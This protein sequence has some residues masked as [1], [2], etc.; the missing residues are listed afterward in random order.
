MKRMFMAAAILLTSVT[1]HAEITARASASHDAPTLH[2]APMNGP[3]TTAFD[4][5]CADV[6]DLAIRGEATCKRVRSMKVGAMRAEIHRVGWADGSGD[7][8]LSI[9]TAQGWFVSDVPLQIE[10]EDGHAGHYDVGTIDSI[11]VAKEKV[12]VSVSIRET[13]TT[14]CNACEEPRD[15]SR[16][17]RAF[18]STATFVCGV[19]TNGTPSCTSPLY[20]IGD[21]AKPPR[22][23][24]TR[25]V[26]RGVMTGEPTEYGQ[27]WHDLADDTY[28]IAL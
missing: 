11:S 13:W 16:P 14:Y 27:E 6:R 21:D 10:T 25:I 9:K 20:T 15:R 3:Y 19:G 26:A 2:G 8:Y 4:E 28:T 7:Y 1:A 22:I 23:V 5:K 24:G 12:G 17:E 18:K